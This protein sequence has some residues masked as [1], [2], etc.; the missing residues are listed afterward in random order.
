MAKLMLETLVQSVSVRD[1]V[2]TGSER[3]GTRQADRATPTFLPFA[4]L[5]SVEHD[6]DLNPDAKRG[7]PAMKQQ[8]GLRAG[9]SVRWSWGHRSRHLRHSSWRRSTRPTGLTPRV[10]ATY[11]SAGYCPAALRR[12][13]Q[14]TAVQ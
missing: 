11:R 4:W 14:P 5:P 13:L 6:A 1:V 9:R 12:G 3:I 10:T 8:R 7:K 2:V